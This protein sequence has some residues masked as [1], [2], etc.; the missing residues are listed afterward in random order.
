MSKIWGKSLIVLAAAILLAA[1][2][3]LVG[4]SSQ[5]AASTSSSAASEEAA[6]QEFDVVVGKESNTAK[7]LVVKNSTGKSIN[8]VALAE[9]GS[10]ADGFNAL[11]VEGEEW[12]DGKVA[13]IYYEPSNAYSFD[14]QLKSG[15]DSY[16]L[17]EFNVDG[18]E[19]I[20]VLMEGD[21]AYVTFERGGD[22]ISSL[23]EETAIHDAKIAEE[24]AAAAAAAEAEAEAEAAQEYYYEETT[25]YNAP[26]APAQTEDQCV[27]GGV[28]LR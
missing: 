22:V 23:S 9:A 27:G 19:N 18:A 26:A 21:V 28:V 1:F 12:A 7:M 8:E 16:M 24:E 20:E 4:C 6:T 11:E 17:H 10:E 5:Q 15:E 3:A 13:A 2:V 14:V 25:T